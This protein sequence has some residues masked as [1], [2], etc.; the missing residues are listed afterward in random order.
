MTPRPNDNMTPTNNTPPSRTSSGGHY[1][2]QQGQRGQQGSHQGQHHDQEP[3]S[4]PCDGV[5]R[6]DVKVLQNLLKRQHRVPNPFRVG[7]SFLAQETLRAIRLGD[8]FIVSIDSEP[9]AMELA[10]LSTGSHAEP[11][12]RAFDAYIMVYHSGSEE[13]I[14]KLVALGKLV[15]LIR[16]DGAAARGGGGSSGHHGQHDAE[17]TTICKPPPDL[18][19]QRENCHVTGGAEHEF[20]SGMLR[21]SR[22]LRDRRRWGS[23]SVTGR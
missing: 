7:V 9:L 12:H 1:D 3:P 14:N 20:D 23:P 18:I 6:G 10:P 15:V 16:L 21:L 17:P 2:G 8:S 11:F 22:R 13:V 19:A 4:Y 5:V